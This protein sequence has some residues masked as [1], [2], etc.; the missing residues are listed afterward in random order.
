MRSVSQSV[1]RHFISSSLYRL[2]FSLCKVLSQLPYV[3]LLMV[4]TLPTISVNL[5]FLSSHIV[6][7]GRKHLN[8]FQQCNSK[9]PH[10]HCAF[11]LLPPRKN[12]D[13]G[14]A[15]FQDG[16]RGREVFFFLRGGKERV[17]IHSVYIAVMY[18]TTAF[19]PLDSS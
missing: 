2:P 1:L 7:L 4:Q 19:K 3:K 18:F 9:V 17:N 14:I 5:Y 15:C 16:E 10:C 6:D 8:I 12:I 11:V 13:D